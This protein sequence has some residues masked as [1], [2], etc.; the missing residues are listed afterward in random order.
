MGLATLTMPAHILVVPAPSLPTRFAQSHT[1]DNPF[2]TTNVET[3]VCVCVCFSPAL[4]QQHYISPA[5]FGQVVG[6]GCP[7]DASSTDHHTG[8][9]GQREQLGV[10]TDS[11]AVGGRPE[12]PAGRSVARLRKQQPGEQDRGKSPGA[13]HTAAHSCAFCNRKQTN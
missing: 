7:H 5:Q 1:T 9:T 6:Y 4:L 10:S 3:F 12:A 8:L 11:H 2:L 13:P